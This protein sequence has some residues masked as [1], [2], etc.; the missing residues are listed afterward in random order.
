MLYYILLLLIPF[1]SSPSS[2]QSAQEI[3]N[4]MYQD[5]G[6]I[7]GF[8]AEI[9]KIERVDD[10]YIV[11]LSSVKLNRQPYK[12]YIKQLAPKK[13]VEVLAS[14]GGE[15][16]VVNLNSF[17]W[18]NIYLDPYGTLMR[19]NQHHLVFDSGFD[20]MIKILKHELKDEGAHNKLIRKEDIFWQGR[21][22]H[23]IEL[24]NNDYAIIN[25][26][27][28]KDEDVDIIAHKLNINAYAVI[29]L[30]EAIDDYDD[31][32]EGQVIKVPN[33]YAKSMSLL[34]DQQTHLPLVI[35]VF[36]NK[37]LY[38]KYEYNSIVL[39]PSFAHDEFTLQYAEYNF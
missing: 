30:N 34:I 13:G 36:D 11:Q 1:S 19:R 23:Q 22:M 26:V 2:G 32:E 20:L 27:V 6:N 35:K 14:K 25:Y 15:K 9:N 17:P 8:V 18:I 12:V 16:A 5:A 31:V 4:L 3:I 39:N 37:G 29:E 21:K 7:N 28:G 24:V 33:H 38:E 10:E